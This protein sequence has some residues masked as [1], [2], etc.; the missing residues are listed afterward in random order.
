MFTFLFYVLLYIEI[1]FL[2]SAYLSDTQTIFSFIFFII[3]S[4]QL[5]GQY[6]FSNVQMH[7]QSNSILY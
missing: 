7:F 2:I 6:V 3:F 4:F 1:Y 5:N